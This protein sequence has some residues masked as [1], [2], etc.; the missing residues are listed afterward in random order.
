MEA[1]GGSDG[2]ND[3]DEWVESMNGRDQHRADLVRVDRTT[4]VD[5]NV[6]N[7]MVSEEGENFLSGAVGGRGGGDLEE[8]A[9]SDRHGTDVGFSAGVLVVDLKH[10]EPQHIDVGEAELS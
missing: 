7:L 3:L 9:Y 10:L 6:R 1:E 5:V 8:D 4:E 2:T